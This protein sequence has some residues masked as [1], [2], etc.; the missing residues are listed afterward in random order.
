MEAVVQV[1]VGKPAPFQLR[2]IGGHFRTI[3]GLS[4]VCDP[5]GDCGQNLFQRLIGALSLPVGLRIE[6]AGQIPTQV[7]GRTQRGPETG[8]KAHITVGKMLRG[9]P[10]R[11]TTP[12]K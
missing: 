2:I 6:T 5:V 3:Q 4:P 1:E 7:H 9:N 10:C 8:Q 12:W 11:R